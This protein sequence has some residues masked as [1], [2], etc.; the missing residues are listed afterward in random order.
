MCII[1]IAELSPACLS[2]VGRQ[3]MHFPC[4]LALPARCGAVRIKQ[5]GGPLIGTI[6]LSRDFAYSL[7]CRARQAQDG[8][9][10]PAM[11]PGTSHLQ[12][13][14]LQWRTQFSHQWMPSDGS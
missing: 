8:L 13:A 7:P 10:P 4:P 9:L 12:Q 5:P 2:S 6:C 11:F 14:V 3:A 1:Y